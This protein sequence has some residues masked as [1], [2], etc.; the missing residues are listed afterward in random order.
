MN[1]DLEEEEEEEEIL[2]KYFPLNII[3]RK[4]IPMYRSIIYNKF[5]DM[6]TIPFK[7]YPVLH[8]LNF[9]IQERND[10]QIATLIVHNVPIRLFN[11]SP[12]PQYIILPF[13]DNSTIQFKRYPVLHA[14]MF[15][16]QR[17]DDNVDFLLAVESFPNFLST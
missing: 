14:R 3:F 11:L 8:S 15:I 17:R 1:F 7:S 13:D 10:E 4:D 12:E 2:D 9:F 5:D 16:F 6:T